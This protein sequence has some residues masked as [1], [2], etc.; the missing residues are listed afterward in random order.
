MAEGILLNG[1]THDWTDVEVR[2]MGLDLGKGITSINY[3][4]SKSKELQY[5]GGVEPH[6]VGYGEKDYSCDFTLTK[7]ASEK[8]EA[9]A[10][11]A[12]K[13]ALDYGPFLIIIN[14][15]EKSADADGLLSQTPGTKT[16]QLMDVDVADIE[17][18]NDQGGKMITV[19]YTAICGKIART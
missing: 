8:F 2:I 14:Y 19:K 9:V 16:V 17:E 15:L 10:H 12:G 6:G 18:S 7:E 11:A 13:S 1:K 3:K 5:A 4:L